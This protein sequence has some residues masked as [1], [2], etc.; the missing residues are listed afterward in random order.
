MDFKDTMQLVKDDQREASLSDPRSAYFGICRQQLVSTAKA[1]EQHFGVA[2]SITSALSEFDAA[3]LIGMSPD[4]YS[5]SMIGRSAVG[6]GHDFIHDGTRYQVK[7]NR[8]SGRKGSFV[9]LVRKASNYDWDKLIWILY[10]PAYAIQEA[11]LWD[12][13]TY[14]A[15]FDL[16][17]RLA[18]A[19]YRQGLR[20]FPHA[21]PDG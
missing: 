16:L 10:D 14:R 20:L 8:P 18:P 21:V 13:E 6:K 4:E 17:G 7:A 19:H 2:P 11:W 9:T 15:A 5:A 3:M 12:V 1:W